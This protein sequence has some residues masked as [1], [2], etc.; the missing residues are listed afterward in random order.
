MSGRKLASDFDL[1]IL[2]LQHFGDDARRHCLEVLAWIPET[3]AGQL[4]QL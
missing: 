4:D 3:Q 2:L 1:G